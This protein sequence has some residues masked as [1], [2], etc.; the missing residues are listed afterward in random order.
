MVMESKARPL[1]ITNEREPIYV[2]WPDLP[3]D[4]KIKHY[5]NYAKELLDSKGG[6][7]IVVHLYELEIPG[8]AFGVGKERIVVT[9]GFVGVID[10]DCCL[11]EFVPF[12]FFYRR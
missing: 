11:K 6:E 9:D 7:V 12:T 5:L 8:I 10:N 4:E 1:F 2:E 3:T